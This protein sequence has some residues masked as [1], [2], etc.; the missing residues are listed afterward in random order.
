MQQ[1]CNI[2]FQSRVKN[3][4]VVFMLLLKN[5]STWNQTLNV[6]FTKRFNVSFLIW[7]VV[8]SKSTDV[9]AV[10]PVVPVPE[11]TGLLPQCPLHVLLPCEATSMKWHIR[12]LF[13]YKC[14]NYSPFHRLTQRSWFGWSRSMCLRI[15]TGR[16]SCRGWSASSTCT[17]SAWPTSPR[18]RCYRGWAVEWT[19]SAS[20]PTPTTRRRPSL[21]SQS[22]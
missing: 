16:R 13:V 5:P 3:G 6:F 12:Q 19:S 10:V 22:E 21:A 7:E 18:P 14:E 11:E 8:W 20:A 9:K 17:T 2:F 4:T 15:R 1:S